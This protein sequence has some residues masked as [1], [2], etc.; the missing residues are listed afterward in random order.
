[1]LEII[2]AILPKSYTD[3]EEKLASIREVASVVQVDVVDGI[4]APNKTWPY[5]G[6]EMFSSIVAQESGLPLWE[7]FD[8]QFDCMVSHTARE[9]RNFISAGASSVVVH[10]AHGN[11]S[12]VLEQFQPDRVGEFGIELGLALLPGEDGATL[13]QYLEH[14]DFVQVMGIAKVGFQGSEFDARAIDLITSLREMYP[15]LTIQIDGGVKVENAQAL[16]RAGANRL[17][18]GSAIFGASD[19]TLAYVALKGEANK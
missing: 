17:V 19:P 16:V 8:F 14:I 10:K 4:F 11:I 6:G 7:D 3:L 2:P 9:V 13:A 18:V 15:T 1:M 5:A 12:E